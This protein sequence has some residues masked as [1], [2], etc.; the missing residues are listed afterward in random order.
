MASINFIARVILLA[1]CIFQCKADQLD[2]NISTGYERISSPLVRIDI[3]SPLMLVEGRSE[4]TGQYYQ[5]NVSGVKDWDLAHDV[6]FSLSGSCSIKTSPSAKDLNYSYASIDGALRKQINEVVFSAGPSVQ[7]IW[8]ADKNFRNS[9]T[10]QTDVIFTKPNGSF[11]DIYLDVSKSYFVDEFDFFNNKSTTVSLTHHINEVGFGFSA[12]D[13]QLSA[14]REINVQNFEDLSNH[15]YYARVSIDRIMLGFTWS[16]GAS[17]TKSNFDAPFYDGFAKRSDQ[18]VSYE[19][20]LEREFSNELRM[21]LDFTKAQNR[22]NLALYESDYQQ[23]NLSLY[24]Q[25]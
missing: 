14:S 4:L 6:G 21:S 20:G 22:S 8:V 19:F 9:I 5:L 1:A 17:L 13:L 23:V 10:L 2:A 24:Y 15:S 7:N 18:Y 3:E 12:L 11:T 25:Y 16:L